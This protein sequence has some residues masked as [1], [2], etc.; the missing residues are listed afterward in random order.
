M[1]NIRLILITIWIFLLMLL[2]QAWQIDYGPRLPVTSESSETSTTATPSTTGASADTSIPNDL[3]KQPVMSGNEV[4]LVGQL[5]RVVPTGGRIRVETDVLK[6]EIDTVGGDIR[7]VFLPG[8]PVSVGSSHPFRMMNDDLPYFF[9]AQSGLLASSDIPNNSPTH[10]SVFQSEKTRYEL[11]NGEERLSVKLQWRNDNGIVVNKIYTFQRDSYLIQLEHRVENHGVQPWHAQVYGQLQRTQLVENQQSSP[12]QTYTGGALS[13]PE[14]RYEKIDFS[15]MEQN[16]L[17]KEQRQGWTGGWAAMLQHYFVAAWIPPRQEVYNYYT[18]AIVDN[19]NNRYVIGG[20]GPVLNVAPGKHEA[21]K[22]QLYIGPKSQDKLAE[23]AP[24]L[25]LTVDYGWLWFISQPLFWGL[26]F[27]YSIVNNWGWAIVILTILIKLAF[28]HLSATSYKSMANMRR[29][30]PRLTELKERYGDDKM[31]FNQAMMEMYKKEK[32][33]PLGG[34]LPILV[35]IP[36]FI[37]LYWVL[38]ESVELRQASFVLWLN[39]LSTAD[40][41]FVLPLIMGATMLLQHKLNP[42]PLDPVQQKVMMILPIVFT[43]FFAFFPSG[44]VLYWVVNN[45][46]SIA[47]QWV[48]TKKIAGDI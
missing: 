2:Y 8:Y 20:V 40:P 30:Q 13:S 22:L 24:N 41:Y 12:V 1:D 9:I 47:Q 23:I 44:L 14:T 10:L 21:F 48:I 3:A 39:D 36:V 25:E 26:E 11:A 42:A 35:Q 43:F 7:R 19:V 38:L 32:V 27:I 6:V 16:Q 33:N 17:A 29:L 45:I 37:A 15:A 4:P 5:E 31:R 28:F 34:C 18:K 46:L